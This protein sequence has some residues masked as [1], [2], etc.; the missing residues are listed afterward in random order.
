MDFSEDLTKFIFNKS[1]FSPLNNR[2]KYSAFMPPQN[3]RLS[4]FRVSGISQPEVWEIGGFI[5]EKRSLPLLA[6]ADIMASAVIETGLEV[7]ADDDPP[8]HANIVGWPQDASDI[9]LK[10]LE[11]A[12]KA[13]LRLR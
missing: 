6:R 13:D 3:R 5:G 1:Q 4:V 10:A 8:R 9:K 7:Y 2:V 12:E 11:L